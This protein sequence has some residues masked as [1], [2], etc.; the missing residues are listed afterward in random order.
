MR[1][2]KTTAY[3][4]I[5]VVAASDDRRGWSIASSPIRSVSKR[6]D[7]TQSRAGLAGLA[8]PNYTKPDSNPV[9]AGDVK[10]I[11]DHVC[12]LG[13][14][15]VVKC[16]PSRRSRSRH[17]PRCR[18]NPDFSI[19]CPAIARGALKSVNVGRTRTIAHAPQQA[20]ST[21]L[22]HR[23][24]PVLRRF[25]RVIFREADPLPR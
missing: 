11:A 14:R 20:R 24:P 19:P 23:R 5:V 8:R 16:P 21:R 1:C 2:S 7:R 3:K 4:G 13:Y 25:P 17:R 10:A 22:V 18:G 15:V 6:C 9:L 12:L